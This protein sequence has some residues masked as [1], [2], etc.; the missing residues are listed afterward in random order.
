MFEEWKSRTLLLLGEEKLE[1]LRKSHVII[2][3][4]GGVGSYAVEF[5]C[6]AGVGEIT[7]IDA[8]VYSISNLNRQL[9][10]TIHSVGKK[11]VEVIGNHLKSINPQVIIH[12]KDL[13]LKD[14]LIPQILMETRYSYAIDAIDTL[15][16]K[17][18]WGYHCYKNNIPLVVSL[19]SGG[20]TN[21][22]L[23]QVTDIDK[24]YN[25]KLG[26][27][28]RKRLHKLGIRKGIKAVFSSE[29]SPTEAII[30]T[31]ED[32]YKKSIVGTISFMP[33]LFGLYCAATVIN[34]LINQENTCNN[35]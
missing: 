8:D 31:P 20:K 7:I 5:I 25:C 23:V 6:R 24:T 16:P 33:A 21:P 14:D 17:T 19:G 27:Y 13:Y 15:S 32:E 1:R 26:F 30:A 29:Q 22:A 2:A 3:G 28:Y 35:V 11:K 12:T 10:A 9:H 18:F 4:L 34:D